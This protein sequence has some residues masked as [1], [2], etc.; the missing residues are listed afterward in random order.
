MGN[1]ERLSFVSFS[2]AC[3]TTPMN[4]VAESDDAVFKSFSK[5]ALTN[6]CHFEKQSFKHSRHGAYEG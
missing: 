1:F 2:P 3:A 4:S 6:C 5:K